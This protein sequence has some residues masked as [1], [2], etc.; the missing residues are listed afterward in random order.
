MRYYQYLA[1][2]LIVFISVCSNA[3]ND[4]S[5]A[6]KLAFRLLGDK[7]SEH[8]VFKK[9]KSKNDIFELKSDKG[10]IIIYGNNANSMA[11]GLGFY[12]KHFCLKDISFWEK[13]TISLP[14]S[15]PIIPIPI[16]REALVKNRF[17]L[18]YCTFGYS[19]V[20]WQ[21]ADWERFIDWMAI[22]GINLPLAITG[23]ES[24]W[25]KV[26]K[27]LGLSDSFLFYRTSSFAMASY[28]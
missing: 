25:Y 4:I 24:V 19:M 6:K 26:W 27:Q 10:K 9:K 12:I 22:N 20:W 5:S 2:S 28:D 18:N 13:D 7:T 17:F 21:W 11:M 23:Q 8:F 15:L 14:D 3:T 1:L 16:I